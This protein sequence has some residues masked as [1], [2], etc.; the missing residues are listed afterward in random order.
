MKVNLFTSCY[1]SGNEIRNAELKYC[2]N[3][4]L[5]AGFSN[6]CFVEDI[7]NSEILKDIS[8]GNSNNSKTVTNIF[9][10]SGYKG[11]YLP[12]NNWFQN[13]SL[14]PDD[15]NI[16]CNSD[17]FFSKETIE[18]LQ[19][20]YQQES[21][22]NK[23]LA[24]S[25]WDFS[26]DKEPVLFERADSQDTWVFFGSPKVKTSIEFFMGYAGCDNRLA[27]EIQQAGYEVLNPCKTI[28]TYHY[29]E[30]NHRTWID[31]DG[32]RLKETVPPPY[33]LVNPY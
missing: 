14:F 29:H 8:I 23:C 33:L 9:F 17:I 19:F 3:Q 18:Q 24:L 2:I 32:N 30:S 26:P 20:F 27:Y 16:L 13:M 15:I 6:M 31:K 11:A 21:N 22:Q 1:N 7:F 25:R 5:K 28:K 10:L 4:N 12:F